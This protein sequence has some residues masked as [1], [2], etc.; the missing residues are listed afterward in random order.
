MVATDSVEL[1]EQVK[2]ALLAENTTLFWAKSGQEAMEVIKG[3]AVA[4]DSEAVP[5]PDLLVSDLQI[6]SMGGVAISYDL[7]LEMLAGRVRKIPVVL[8][9]D[10]EADIFL[11]KEVGADAYIVKPISALKLKRISSEVLALESAGG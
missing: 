6:G 8:L 7:Q 5:T 9:L 3:S 2:S 4:K 1:F 11:A 10:R